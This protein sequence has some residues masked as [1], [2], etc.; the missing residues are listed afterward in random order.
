MRDQRPHGSGMERSDEMVRLNGKGRARRV[1]VLGL[2]AAVALLGSASGAGAQVAASDRPAGYVVLPKIVV[3]TTAGSPAVLPGGTAIDTIVQLTNTNESEPID[4]DCWWVNANNHCGGLATGAIC[5]TNAECPPGLLC[6]PR[7]TTL[8]FQV[9]LTPG[10]PIGFTASSGINPVPCDPLFPGPGCKGQ[11]SNSATLCTSNNGCPGGM[12]CQCGAGE[13]LFASGMIR[14]VPE[15]PFRGELKC[16]Q[17]DGDDD[18]IN[19]NDLKAEATV[20][21]TIVPGGATTPATTAA[22]YNGIGFEADEGFTPAENPTFPLCLGDLPV[23]TPGGISCN[24]AYAPCP[25]ILILN[26]FFERA[27]PEIG[28]VVNTELT[29][30]PCSEDLGDPVVSANFEVLAQIL[31]FN[32]FE[33]RFSTSTTVECYRNSRLSDIDTLPGPSGDNFSIYAVGTQGTLTGQSRIRGVQGPPG[34]LGYG[35]MGVACEQYRATA[36]GQI[37]ATTAFNLHHDG[38][39]AGDAVYLELLPQ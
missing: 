34:R 31:I 6:L 17:V 9:R 38:F 2:I 23:G 7:W 18:P 13:C 26:H 37:L 15:D 35:L 25:G 24:Q 28:G 33:Q 8:D 22:A 19:Q 39:S 36:S 27:Q 4:V 11:C 3:H 14:P 21:S 29:L 30:V 32:E 5:N 12:T 20:V 10:Q 1:S 16:V